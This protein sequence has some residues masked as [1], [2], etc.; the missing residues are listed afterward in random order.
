MAYFPAAFS[1]TLTLNKAEP[2]LKYRKQ[3]K[4]TGSYFITW[5]IFW[6]DRIMF[7]D[8]TNGHVYCL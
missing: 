1:D 6:L 5:L 4:K 3:G 7:F 8:P 2:S